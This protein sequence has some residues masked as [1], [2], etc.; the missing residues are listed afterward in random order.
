MAQMQ[1]TVRTVKSR[2][3]KS[4]GV[5]VQVLNASLY[6][7]PRLSHRLSVANQSEKTLNSMKNNNEVLSRVESH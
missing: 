2:K 4:R 1:F 7:P 5:I 3:K 6:L